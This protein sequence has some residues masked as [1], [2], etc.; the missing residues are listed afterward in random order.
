MVSGYIDNRLVREGLASPNDAFD[1]QTMS[2]ANTAMSAI[3]TVSGFGSK[4]EDSDADLR[5]QVIHATP[6]VN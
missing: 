2:R 1:A 6:S 3:A 4:S 5:E